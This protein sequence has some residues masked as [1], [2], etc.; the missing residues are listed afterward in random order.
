MRCEFW[1]KMSGGRSPCLAQRLGRRALA[2]VLARESVVLCG[3][4]WAEAMVRHLDPEARIG[5]HVAEGARGEPGQ[6]RARDHGCG[7][8]LA[9]HRAHLSPAAPLL[10]IG[11]RR[12][13]V[14]DVTI[15]I[16]RC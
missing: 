11:A 3:A 14:V 10:I 13:E 9:H 8:G 2:R 12:R 15:N 6:S 7:E 16:R 1:T 4:P 5:W